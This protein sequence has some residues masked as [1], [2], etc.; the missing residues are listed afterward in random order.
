MLKATSLSVALFVFL[1]I[2]ADIFSSLFTSAFCGILMS[3]PHRHTAGKDARHCCTPI[4]SFSLG[5][6]LEVVAVS[7]HWIC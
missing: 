5:L 4:C 2:I 7:S 6:H 1:F 3:M